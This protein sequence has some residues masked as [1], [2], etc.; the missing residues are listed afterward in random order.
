MRDLPAFVFMAT[1][2]VLWVS[3][4]A[5]R[6]LPAVGLL[7]AAAIRFVGGPA[8]LA[9]PSMGDPEQRL[10]A[11]VS[12]AGAVAFYG[13]VWGPARFPGSRS[14]AFL[15]EALHIVGGPARAVDLALTWV[16]WAGL[17]AMAWAS[18]SELFPWQLRGAHE[19]SGAVPAVAARAVADAVDAD[20]RPVALAGRPTADPSARKRK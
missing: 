5:T 4:F 10:A 9:Y 20:E 6:E 19:G 7:G 17:A 3:E 11:L 2:L 14:F 18:S 16:G 8:L 15:L 1:F 12:M 13:G